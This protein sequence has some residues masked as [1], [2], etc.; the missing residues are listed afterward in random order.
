M[1]RAW[2]ALVPAMCVALVA[3]CTAS[4]PAPVASA[5]AATTPSPMQTPTP[6]PT[7]STEVQDMS[8]TD[9]GIVFEDVPSL[10]GPEAEVYNLLSTY[11]TEYWRTMTTN[12][13]SPAF[14]ILASGDVQSTMKGIVKTNKDGKIALGGVFSTTI[15]DVKVDGEK[16]T[17]A[18]CDDYAKMTVKDPNGTYTPQEVG[19]G[20]P[21]HKDVTVTRAGSG[22]TWRVQTVKVEGSC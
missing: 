10:T 20:V 16:A 22:M 14:S 13:V 6:T 18:I 9:L 1:S 2:W 5:P 4:D 12:A 17:A 3:G 11:Q 21:R 19:Y 15:T 8:S 7:P